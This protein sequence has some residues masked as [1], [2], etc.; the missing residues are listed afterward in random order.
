[1][2]NTYKAPTDFRAVRKNGD[3]YLNASGYAFAVVSDMGDHF[4]MHWSQFDTFGAEMHRVTGKD[5]MVAGKDRESFMR[6]LATAKKAFLVAD[7]YDWDQA[8]EVEA[9]RQTEL[10]A[11][12]ALERNDEH[13]Y[14]TDFEDRMG[15]N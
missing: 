10:A 12:R 7:R 14:W 15:F 5:Q 11:E 1:M 2:S 9:D 4:L 6:L 3:Y 8:Q 13:A